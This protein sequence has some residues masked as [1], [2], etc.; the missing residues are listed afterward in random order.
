MSEQYYSKGSKRAKAQR[1]AA[2]IALMKRYGTNDPLEATK[3]LFI[4]MA[5][6]SSKARAEQN[7]KRRQGK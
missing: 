5:E 2:R 7:R 1:R 3:R 4:E 6:A